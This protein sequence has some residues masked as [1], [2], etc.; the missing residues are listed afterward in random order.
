MKAK[1]SVIIPI[2]N[3]AHTLADSLR[4]IA[5]QTYAPAEIIII[6]DGSTDGLGQK[7]SAIIKSSGLD[8]SLIKF[9]SQP[10]QGASQARNAGFAKSSSDLVIFWDADTIAH[11]EMLKK[12]RQALL[13][14]PK[15]AY[16]YCGYKFGC[17]SMPSFAFEADKLKKFNYIDTT[18]LIRRKDFTGFDP[19]LKRFQDW[20]LWLTLLAQN[21]TGVFVPKILYKK[22]VSKRAGISRW[23]P[24]FVYNMPFIKT[25]SVLQY[26]QARQALI[27]KHS[28]PNR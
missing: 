20:D 19:D 7:I 3:H 6:D 9:S 27:K 18:S 4:S 22:I 26:Q 23:L 2:Y 17:K 10:N 12:L 13:A 11:P 21:K 16:A 8:P 5:R 25:K 24:A 14:S 15:S 28:L 1:I